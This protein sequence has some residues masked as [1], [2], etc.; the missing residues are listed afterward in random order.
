MTITPQT[1]AVWAELPMGNLTGMRVSVKVNS[2][3]HPT[4]TL[5]FVSSWYP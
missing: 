4:A 2:S 3:S 1:A 5:M